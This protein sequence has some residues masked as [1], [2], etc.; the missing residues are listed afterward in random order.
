M[1]E[2]NILMPIA[3][4]G[5]R[6]AKAGYVVP[7]PLIDILGKPMIQLVVENININGNYIYIAQKEH[8]YK[9]NLE[10]LLNKITPNCKII[11]VDGITEGAACT[12]L[13][14]KKHINNE[15]PLL[16][17]N[18]DQFIVW[19]STDFIQS[20]DICDGSILT[21][22]CSNDPKLSYVKLDDNKHVIEIKEKQP[23]SNKATVGVYYWSLG[24][25]YVRYAES[26]IAQNKRTNGEFY[27]APVYQEAL[28]DKKIIKTYDVEEMWGIGTPDCLNNFLKNYKHFPI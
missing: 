28:D 12:T 22:N 20:I 7:K 18:S 10:H 4:A 23:I 5:S 24:S 27:V 21:F 26:M 3:G 16:I 6:F 9:H 19:K 11:C 17:V 15:N 2:L 1:K 8:Y 25:E 13:I 14:A